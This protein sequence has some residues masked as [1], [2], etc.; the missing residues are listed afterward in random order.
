M[1][2]Q[3]SDTGLVATRGAG[4]ASA[5]YGAISKKPLNGENVLVMRLA[6]AASQAIDKGLAKKVGLLLFVFVIFNFTPNLY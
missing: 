1:I 2:L 3:V 5:G 4:D 6:E